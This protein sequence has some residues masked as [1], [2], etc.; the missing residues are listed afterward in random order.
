MTG[1]DGAPL[2][3]SVPL[4]GRSV[5]FHVWCGAVGGV[6]M[7]LL[8]TEREENTTIDRWITARLYEGNRSDPARAV[9]VPRPRRRARAARLGIDPAVVHL[10]EGH[11]VLAALE[12][13]AEAVAAGDDFDD[14]CA[15]VRRRVVFT[16]HTPVPAGNESYSAEELGAVV[17]D[18]PGRLG[19]GLEQLRGARPHPIVGRGGAGVADRDGAAVSAGTRTA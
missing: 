16:T 4:L 9:R 10:N 19:I 14:A 8:D 1:A 7:Y 11:A 17:G 3:V 5:L 13:A 2:S 15:R 18:L 12:L 6:P